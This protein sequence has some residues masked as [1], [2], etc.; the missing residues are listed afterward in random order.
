M[1]NNLYEESRTA[2]GLK[3]KNLRELRNFTQQYMAEQ[4]NM[5]QSGYSKIE[6]G[7]T[8]IAFS[9]L[10][11]IAGVLEVE[12]AD[13]VSFDNQ[14][15]FQSFNNIKGNGSGYIIQSDKIS[16]LYEDKIALMEKV[17]ANVEQQLNQYKDRFGDIV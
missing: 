12:V 11:D 14:K 17:L 8:D 1:G 5:K 7:E 16:K 9:K 10:Q 6:K 3:I 2:I 15:F 4:L 13:I